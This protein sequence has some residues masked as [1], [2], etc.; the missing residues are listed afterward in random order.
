M[1]VPN[2]SRL[3]ALARLVP[4]CTASSP[5]SLVL[6]HARIDA[7]YY[8]IA[9]RV[10]VSSS[11]EGPSEG[12]VAHHPVGDTQLWVI[13]GPD[14]VRGNEHTCCRACCRAWTGPWRAAGWRWT[15][16]ASCCPCEGP[17][18]QSCPPR[19][20]GHYQSSTWPTAARACRSSQPPEVARNGGAAACHPVPFQMHCAADVPARSWYGCCV[21]GLCDSRRVWHRELMLW[22]HRSKASQDGSIRQA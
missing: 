5:R 2:T 19:R 8:L 6:K 15:S 3:S 4:Y 16:G 21:T 18:R 7:T 1:E 13:P 12:L 10:P 11:C 9:A 22:A 20:A 17:L 14:A